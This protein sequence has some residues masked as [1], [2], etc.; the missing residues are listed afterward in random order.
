MI[1]RVVQRRV[2]IIEDGSRKC[3]IEILKMC[4][5]QEE[6]EDEVVVLSKRRERSGG[7]VCLLASDEDSNGRDLETSLDEEVEIQVEGFFGE[8]RTSGDDDEMSGN[9]VEILGSSRERDLGEND[10]DGD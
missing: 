2:G 4:W 8:F 3:E 7:L 1:A 5:V 6:L 10:F 9:S